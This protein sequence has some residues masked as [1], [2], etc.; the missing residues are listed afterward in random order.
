LIDEK[1]EKMPKMKLQSSFLLVTLLADVSVA[2]VQAAH[3][4][5]VSDAQ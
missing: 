2:T 1:L 3:G 4:I 5:F